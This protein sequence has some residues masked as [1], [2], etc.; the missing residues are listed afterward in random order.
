MGLTSQYLEQSESFA[1]KD[2]QPIE[3]KFRT[4]NVSLER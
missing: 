3:C 1:G 4:L 2:V